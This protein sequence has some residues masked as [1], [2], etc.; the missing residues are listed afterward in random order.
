MNTTK[1]QYLADLADLARLADLLAKAATE[2]EHDAI[3]AQA[4]AIADQMNAEGA[5]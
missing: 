4:Q 3:A 5:E 2:A 1:A